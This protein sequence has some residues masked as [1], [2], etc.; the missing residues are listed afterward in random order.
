MNRKNVIHNGRGF[1]LIEL[2]AVLAILAIIA[3][4]ATPAISTII[5]DSKTKSDQ[6]SISM[7]EESGAIAEVAGLQH[8]D[9]K[10]E[11]YFVTTLIDEGFL[12]FDE[13][14]HLS[15]GGAYVERKKNNSGR[16]LY[17]GSKDINDYPLDTDI[18]D[19]NGDVLKVISMSPANGTFK[20]GDELTSTMQVQNVSDED[21]TFV[22]GQT[23][24]D[25]KGDTFDGATTEVGIK[26]GETKTL[27]WLWD[28]KDVTVE[29][30]YNTQL[31]VWE[32]DWSERYINV[33]FTDNIYMTPYV[34][35]WNYMTAPD[36][37]LQDRTIGGIDWSDDGK[38]PEYISR[39]MAENVTLDD[40]KVTI[41]LP[42]ETLHSGQVRSHQSFGYGS[43]E[44]RMQVVDGD[45]ELSGFFLYTAPDAQHE[46]DMEVLNYE[47]KWQ[48]WLTIH[49][50]NHAKFVPGKVSDEPGE[51]FK[52]KIPLNFDPSKG[53][54]DYRIDYYPDYVAFQVD[55]KEVARWSERFD[56]AKMQLFA[57]AFYAHWL[58]GTAGS[59]DR[60]MDIEHVR[61]GYFE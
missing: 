20:F 26:A 19:V 47:G 53:M 40:R 39:V 24:Y 55:G 36:W 42:E 30:F 61:Y 60:T 10:R 44:S 37:A 50:K 18:N 49:N 8:D 52:E 9:K 35:K 38:Y 12:D 58:S 46:I 5:G 59:T 27:E 33:R 7:I 28:S 2:M 48:L 22:L 45:A 11:R 23:Y 21:H 3:L 6:T 56:F 51:I 41:D 17:R 32:S 15:L 1:T 4:I 34:D 25:P 29:G 13:G 31:T 16:Y 14:H 43:Y 54:H 57:G